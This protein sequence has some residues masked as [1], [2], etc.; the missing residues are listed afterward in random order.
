M[1]QTN[2][3]IVQSDKTLLLDVHA[4]LAEECRDALIPFAELKSSP[5]HLHTYNLSPLSLWNAASAGFTADDV[6]GVLKRFSRF[7]IPQNVL[8][9]IKETASRFGKL[10]LVPDDIEEPCTQDEKEDKKIPTLLLVCDELLV[11]KEI[12]SNK[13]LAKYL[14]PI[15][16][17]NVHTG[18]FGFR[19]Q[20]TNR[21]I[22][23]QEL[24]SLLWPVKDEVPLR[25]GDPLE[26][27]L[28]EKT[29]KNK[30]LEIREYQKQSVRSFLGDGGPGTGYGTIVL[31]CGAGKTVVGI[32]L[33]AKLNMST[34]IVTTNISAVHQWK[35]ELLDKT[36]LTEDQIGE[37]TGE[38]KLIKPV[39]IATYQILTWRPEKEGPFPHFHVFNERN[40]GLIIYDEV[41][42]LPAPVFR[43]AAE[44][45][46]IRRIG[47]TATL[48]REDGFEK[49]VFSLVGPK[50]YDVPWKELERSGWI[51]QSE[52][53]EMRL[54][55]AEEKQ[56]DY[57]TASLRKKHR[58]ACENPAKIPVV[59][60]LIE[61][62]TD[63]KILVI[64]QYLDQLCELAELQKAPIITGKTPNA[65]R[66]IIYD[67]FR[68]G[69]IR[70][71]FVSKVANFAIDL[72]D[73]SMAIQISGTFG[74]RQEEAQRLGRILRPKKKVARFIT[75]VTRNTEEDV[76][77][78]NRQKF[79][80]EQGYSYRM[81]NSIEEIPEYLEDGR[82][83]SGGSNE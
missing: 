69:E 41:H 54:D 52:C 5:E 44:I 61:R 46:A 68:K 6:A 34:L 66:D 33:M 9:W 56:I 24:I 42:L 26:V 1:E 28:R 8:A 65:Q 58:I 3:L 60:S 18:S 10:R 17:E 11:F 25:D 29:L 16:D 14:L 20:L 80:A 32:A 78:A 45:Q 7:D 43:I 35:A 82:C 31:P 63:D 39:T 23:K 15:N 49:H 67:S 71:L 70:V 22:I 74:S 81:V 83:E 37:Y 64:G 47:L 21:G 59:L 62:F 72:P 36:E 38:K 79:L 77:G 48:V 19:L 27:I 73:A 53:I 51:A 57:A 12:L 2:P 55:M 76:F 13:K 40:W 50:R 4:P 30:P 75:L